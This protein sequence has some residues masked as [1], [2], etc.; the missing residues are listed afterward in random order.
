MELNKAITEHCIKQILKVV[1][2][3]VM[4]EESGTVL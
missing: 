1:Q 3:T 2:M 4:S